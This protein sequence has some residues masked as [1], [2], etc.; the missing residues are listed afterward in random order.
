MGRRQS[1]GIRQK[2]SLGQVFLNTDWPVRKV[3][4]K[5]SEWKVK[6]VIEI[7]PGPG[8]LTRALLDA[9]ILVTAVER[10]DRFVERLHDYRNLAHPDLAARLEIVGEDILK[11][12]LES[13]IDHSHE[14]AAVV[15]NIP[16]NISSPII[17]WSLP[18]L[19]RLKGV[20]FLTQLEFATRLAGQVGTK[21][22]GSLS[23]FTQLRSLVSIDCKVE[24]T[25][26]NPVPKVDSALVTLRP[27]TEKLSPKKLRAVETITRSAFTQRR[28]ILKNAVKQYLADEAMI[29]QCPIDLNRRPDSLRPEEY[30]ELANFIFSKK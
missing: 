21:A 29:A 30:I 5:M 17:M 25:C 22:Y 24:R 12:D 2:K 20:N 15:G 3:V 7:G 16:Y 23:V 13:W 14:A 26:F 28:K 9:G 6:R 8:I 18:Y 1:G 10:D 27:R 19:D 11:F 4:D